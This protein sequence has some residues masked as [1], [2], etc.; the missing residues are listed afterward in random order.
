MT[1]K[2]CLDSVGG[3]CGS[4]LG[5]FQVDGQTFTGE[6][7]SKK[8]AKKFAAIKALSELYGIQY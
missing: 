8:E 6:G 5:N 2:V 3:R 1:C 7:K 4:H